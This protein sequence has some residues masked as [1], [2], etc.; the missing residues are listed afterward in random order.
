RRVAPDR[1]ISTV[2]TQARHVHK[3]VH[4]RQDGYKAHVVIEPDTGL[5]TAVRLTM[6]AGAD[7][8]EAVVG[9]DLLAGEPAGA[10]AAPLT[11]PATFEVLADTAY[12]TG[13]ARRALLDAGHTVIIKPAPLRPAVA[14]GFTIDDFTVD[15]AAGTGTCPAGVTRRITRTRQVVFGIAC[16]SCPL[17]E[18]CTTSKHGRTLHLHPHDALLRQARRQWATDPGL[19]AVYRQ[20]RPMVERSIA[21]LIGADGGAR[22][23]RYRGIQRNNLWLHLRAAALNLRRLINLG[24]TPAQ[25]TWILQPATG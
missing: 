22:R 20:H 23:L 18:R 17:R 16:R 2:D 3:T 14:G 7:Q 6:A 8:H 21:W 24:L 5:F 15:E 19:R 25:G 1:V 11:G 4:Q 13:E 10:S 9:V 12:G